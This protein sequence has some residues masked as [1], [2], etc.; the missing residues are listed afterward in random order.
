MGVGKLKTQITY[1]RLDYI[2]GI[3]LSSATSYEDCKVVFQYA[4]PP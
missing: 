2:F 1:K 4:L 3:G